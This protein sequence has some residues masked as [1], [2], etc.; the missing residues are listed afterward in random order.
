MGAMLTNLRNVVAAGFVLTVIIYVLVRLGLGTGIG[1]DTA[2][3]TFCFRGLHVISG[4]MWIGLL[5]YFNFVQIPNMDKIPDAQKP[6]IGKVIAPAALWWFRW[7]AMA[8][9]V[10]GLILAWMNGYLRDA[11]SV[12]LTDNGSSMPIGIG[13]WLGIIMWINVWFGVWPNQNRALGI[14]DVSSEEKSASA[15][16][17]MLFLRANTLLSIPMLF[18][19][20]GMSHGGF[21]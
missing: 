14:V 15:R 20:V 12:G 2:W 16:A 9:M 5:W 8:T 6:A 4:T 21:G 1:L 19:M 18:C 17:A 13:M 11:L 7:S 10:T 3:W